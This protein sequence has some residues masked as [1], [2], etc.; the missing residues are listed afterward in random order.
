MDDRLEQ[1]QVTELTVHWIKAQPKVADFIALMVPGFHDAEDILQRVAVVVTQKYHQFDQSRSFTDWVIGITKYE[2][3]AFRR[4]KA[5]DRHVFDE[6]LIE[7]IASRYAGI[8]PKLER[9]RQV[10]QECIERIQGRNR[11]VLEMW[12][13]E[14]ISQ[15]QIAERLK[16]TPNTV[17]VTLHR[18]RTLLR[19]CVQRRLRLGWRS[20]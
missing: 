17:Y 11:R 7:Q 18:I 9:A 20:P 6:S 4:S 3:L 8:E 14:E 13:A 1:W 15:V 10:M 12:Y 19:N 2:I 16:T 5:R